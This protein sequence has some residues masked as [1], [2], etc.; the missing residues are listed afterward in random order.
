MPAGTV[1]G[2]SARGTTT[3]VQHDD[4]VS[5]R[6]AVHLPDHLVDHDEEMLAIARATSSNPLPF[7]R[8]L[9]PPAGGW[10]TAW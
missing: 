3:P 8:G 2:A 7:D 1:V 6:I 4:G 9:T 10:L 5:T